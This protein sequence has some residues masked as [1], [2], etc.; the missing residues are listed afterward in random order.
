MNQVNINMTLNKQLRQLKNKLI[1]VGLE[2]SIGF[3]D[4]KLKPAISDPMELLD[5]NSFSNSI[6]QLAG[7]SPT[8]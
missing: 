6:R 5:H 3:Y 1:S 7:L 2:P 4:V 8:S